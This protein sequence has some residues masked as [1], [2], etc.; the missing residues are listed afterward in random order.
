[1]KFSVPRN[2]KVS[3]AVLLI[4]AALSGPA[5]AS[6]QNVSEPDSNWSSIHGTLDGWHYGA[7]AQINRDNVTNLGLA[8]SAD[9]ATPSGLVGTPVVIDGVVYQSGPGGVVDAHEVRTG[10]SKWVFSPAS[11]YKEKL[12]FV[13]FWAR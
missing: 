9:I 4:P 5:C 10:K 11:P 8:W 2:I 13:A 1:M 7:I 12:S 3:T 6:D